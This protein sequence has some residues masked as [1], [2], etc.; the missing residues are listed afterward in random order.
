[1]SNS[2]SLAFKSMGHFFATLVQKVL[3]A[4][5]KIVAVGTAVENTAAQVESVT[6]LIPVYGPL[7]VTA[8]KAAYA[9]IGE[10]MAALKAGGA[11]AEAKLADLGLDSAVVDTVKAVAADPLIQ[12]LVKLL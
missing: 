8:E 7:A 5:P 2:F 12:K 3:A 6:A 10:V 1:M 9:L 4:E 11:A